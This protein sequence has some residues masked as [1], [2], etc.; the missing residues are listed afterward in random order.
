VPRR[1]EA[2]LEGEVKKRYN[3]WLVLDLRRPTK[4]KPNEV[5]AEGEINAL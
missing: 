2:T 4:L 3:G 5:I 1:D